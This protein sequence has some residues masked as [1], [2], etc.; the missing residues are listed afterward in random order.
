[1]KRVSLAVV[2]QEL[3]I[4]IQKME[5]LMGIYDSATLIDADVTNS[6]EFPA[7]KR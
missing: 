7:L 6:F 1:M 2:E 3:D 5:S 4:R